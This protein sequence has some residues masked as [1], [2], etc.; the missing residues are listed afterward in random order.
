MP[1]SDPPRLLILGG[2]T[3]GADLA[4]G[5]ADWHGGKIDVTTSLAGRTRTPEP[6]PG[7]VRVGGFGG[8]GAMADYLRVHRIDAVVDA[9]HPFAA[10][11]SANAV[12]ACEFAGVPRLA[13]VRPEWQPQP[14]D[15]WIFFDTV[16]ALAEALPRYGRRA[17][18]TV[19]SQELAAF[20]RLAD[21]WFLVRLVDP[22]AAPLP[23]AECQIVTGR[24]PFAEADERHLMASYAI[25]VL[26]TRASGGSA[27]APKLAAARRLGLPVTMIRRPPPPPGPMVENAAAAIIWI[28]N[29]LRP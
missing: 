25:D 28:T 11:I 22:P 18:L 17:F 1:V 6:L 5:L 14:G 2:T 3:E 24:G 23:L 4:R 21:L 16:A 19:G 29:S 26:V 20:A 27:T 9:T 12:T 13:V 8:A 15:Q 10:Q 7:K